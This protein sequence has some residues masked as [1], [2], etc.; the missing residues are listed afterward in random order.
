MNAVA[1]LTKP[2][3]DDTLVEQGRAFAM[4]DSSIGIKVADG[5]FY[6]VLES[7]FTGRKRLV[8]TTAVDNQP[9][10]QIDLYR[11]NGST[12]SA[13]QYIGSLII[14]NIRAA[15]QGEPEI[16]LLIGI[17]ANGQLSAEANDP[18][19]GESQKFATRLAGFGAS[20]ATV[21]EFPEEEELSETELAM[22]E[23]EAPAAGA[24]AREPV[25]EEGVEAAPRRRPSLL[26]LIL[27]VVLGV[28][29]VAAVAYFVYRNVQGSPA[30]AVSAKPAATSAAASPA[31]PKPAPAPAPAPAA[32]TSQAAATAATAPASSTTPKTPAPASYLIKR[33]DTLW[34][35]AGTYYRNPWLYPKIAKANGIRNPDLIFAGTRITIPAN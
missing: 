24:A 13:G 30:G 5:S 27:F 19:T 3:G 26:L 4:G 32:S 18:S 33:G 7:G 10:A 16:E 17:D 9:R 20:A 21:A 35:L 1:G 31:A 15:A 28:L 12:V 2:P 22:D 11:G 29:L 14:E 25:R 23:E 6:P 8:L 34:D